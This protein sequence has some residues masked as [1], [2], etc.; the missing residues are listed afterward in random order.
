M[1]VEVEVDLVAVEDVVEVDVDVVTEVNVNVVAAEDVGLVAEVNVNVVAVE[2]VGLVAEV[3]VN[4][5]AVEDVGL[6]AE[7]E[8]LA[9]VLAAFLR[10]SFSSCMRRTAA[11]SKFGGSW[12][13]MTSTVKLK[14]AAATLE[15]AVQSNS[16]F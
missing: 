5:V 15:P 12:L 11:S 10:S 8:V 6:V 7:V 1:V 2:D 3:D 4:A 13:M 16:S 14:T 9:L